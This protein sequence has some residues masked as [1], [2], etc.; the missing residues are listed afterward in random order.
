MGTI[1]QIDPGK[2]AALDEHL[3]ARCPAL[4]QD[5]VGACQQFGEHRSDGPVRPGSP[6][7]DPGMDLDRRLVARAKVQLGADRARIHRGNQC[8][9]VPTDVQHGRPAL[10]MGVGLH[11]VATVL[12][13]TVLT[14]LVATVLVVVLVL[15]LVIGIG[16]GAVVRRLD[17]RHDAAGTDS[18]LTS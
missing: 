12:I 1:S 6:M 5:P 13:M 15:V 4:I 16:I 18:G 11:Q 17:R 3:L 9:D 2:F 7:P 14:V 8:S 10:D